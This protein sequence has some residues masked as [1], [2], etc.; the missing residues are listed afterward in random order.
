MEEKRYR[1]TVA[2]MLTAIIVLLV[3]S[4]VMLGVL[5]WQTLHLEKETPTPPTPTAQTSQEV[6]MASDTQPDRTKWFSAYDAVLQ[7]GAGRSVQLSSYR[8]KPVVLLF[9]SSWCP[10]CKA[11]F[12]GDC[13]AAMAAAEQ[14]GAEVLLI[15]REGM[16]GDNWMLAEQ[17]LTACGMTTEQLLMDT[18]AT[19]YT[20][21]GLHSVPSMVV[22]D[23][24]GVMRTARTDMPD[25]QGMVALLQSVQ[26]P[27]ETTLSFLTTYV[28]QADGA[29]PS[30]YRMQGGEIVLNDTVLSETMGL[31]MLYAVQKGD[32]ALFTQ[33]W[34]YVRDVMS[35]GGLTAWRM[36]N[37]K[38][39]DVNASLDDLRILKALMCAEDTWGGYAQEIAQRAKALYDACVVRGYLVDHVTMDRMKPSDSVTLCY[40]DTQTM[41]QLATYDARWTAVAEKT[42]ALF[43]QERAL[44]S[45]SLPLYRAAYNPV[46]ETFTDDAPQMTEA[47]IALMY[48]AQCGRL[49]EK[50]Q[51]WLLQQLTDGHVYAWY[52]KNGAVRTGYR[53]EASATYAVLAQMGAMMQQ[54]E[55]TRLSMA[56]L[57]GSRKNQGAMLGAYGSTAGEQSYTF[58]EVQALLSWQLFQ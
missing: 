33:C 51:E 5:I 9:F 37:G 28:M 44:V 10:D 36:E 22:L 26:Q 39:A 29:I 4:G 23:E 15:C 20:A 32:E 43:S 34:Q 42:E 45:E 14:S 58:D 2:I 6:L 12:R 7:D 13:Q 47:A 31:M 25:A 1:R 40:Q 18:S 55:I 8:G 54:T 35:R 49:P 19:L 57:E 11:Y 53:Y 17:E 30:G 3:A 56:L 27:E 16:R 48:A 46:K 21:M 41:R 24:N 52:D 38:R 50:T